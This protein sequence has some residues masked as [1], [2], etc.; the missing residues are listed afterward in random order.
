LQIIFLYLE[1]GE[2][3]GRP[4]GEVLPELEVLVLGE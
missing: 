3:C 1:E 2:G 4:R